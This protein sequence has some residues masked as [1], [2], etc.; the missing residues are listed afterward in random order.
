MA[1]STPPVDSSTLPS[2]VKCAVGIFSLLFFF[3]K[4]FLSVDSLLI[5]ASTC[6]S[7][8]GK[9]ESGEEGGERRESWKDE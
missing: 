5:E 9:R 8:S 1:A 3:V 2:I 7:G 4:T 6:L